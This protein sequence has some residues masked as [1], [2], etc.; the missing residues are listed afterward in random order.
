MCGIKEPATIL[1]RVFPIALSNVQADGSGSAV[2]L[3]A[4]I[5]NARHGFQQL[6]EP[7]DEADSFLVDL[8][9]FMIEP[10][11]CCIHRAAYLLPNLTLNLNLTPIAGGDPGATR[12][13]NRIKIRSKI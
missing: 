13:G 9:L 7:G 4:N 12:I 11:F 6:R 8:Q 2:E 10:E 3:I 1:Q 5:P